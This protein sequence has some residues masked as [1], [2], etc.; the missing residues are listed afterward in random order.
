MN[1]IVCIDKNNGM[2]FN[3]RRQ[4]MDKIVRQHILMDGRDSVLWMNDYTASQFEK[5]LPDFV[6]VDNDFLD[7]A[8]TDDY[9]FVE[10]SAIIPYNDKIKDIIIYNW[11][12]I[13]PADM[14]LDIDLNNSSRKLVSE[15]TF[16]GNSHD[17]ILKQI[18][19]YTI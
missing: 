11:N 18:Y 15:E 19:K 1:I 17:E 14:H 12:R 5:P 13:Y 8:G 3:H 16:P 10:N 4:S 9:V 2:L 6:H 7:K